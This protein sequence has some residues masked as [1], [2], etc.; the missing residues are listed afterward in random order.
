MFKSLRYLAKGFF[1]QYFLLLL[2]VFLL[3]EKMA[4]QVTYSV[5][6]KYY[7][8]KIKLLKED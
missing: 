6:L 5:T 2:A 8:L 1:L 7:N 3:Y 4:F